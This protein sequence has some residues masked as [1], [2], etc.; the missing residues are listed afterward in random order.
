MSKV[1]FDLILKNYIQN[2]LELD[3]TDSLLDWDIDLLERNGLIQ[4]FSSNSCF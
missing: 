4:K 2:K 1:D 3:Y